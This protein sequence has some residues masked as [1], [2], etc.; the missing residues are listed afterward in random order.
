MKEDK[1]VLPTS[2]VPIAIDMAHRGH[3]G[4]KLCTRLL[5]ENFYF[6][7][8][9]KKVNEKISS[10]NACD[11]NTDTTKLNP[12]LS[13]HMPNEKWDLIA[14]DFSS[15]TPTGEYILVLVCEHSRYPI[16]KLAKDLTSRETIRILTEVFKEFGTP[17]SIKSDNGPVFKSAEFSDY[18]TNMKITHLKVTPLWPRANG[19]CEKFLRNINKVIRCSNSANQNWKE[20]MSA[21]LKNYRATPHS[22]TGVTPNQLMGFENDNGMPSSNLT[23][24]RL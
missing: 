16:L 22:T 11:A 14:I 10:C 13:S 19:M 4:A 21:Y 20:N 1:I 17:K 8:I 15:R 5:K 9:E 2:L 18:C 23:N 3:M 7:L 12:I 6:P 24:K